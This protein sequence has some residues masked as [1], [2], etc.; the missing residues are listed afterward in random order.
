MGRL[1]HAFAVAEDDINRIIHDFAIL[2]RLA[3][4]VEKQA[5]VH[6]IL[7]GMRIAVARD[8]LKRLLRVTGAADS[9]CAEIN[10]VL[11]Q[12][13]EIQFFRDRIA[14]NGAF[15]DFEN[16][17]RFY[18]TNQIAARE[19]EQ[20]EWISFTPAILLDMAHDLELIPYLID[21]ALASPG[22]RD[23]HAALAKTPEDRQA[24]LDPPSRPWRYRPSQ[25]V[26]T[27][28]RYWRNEALRRE[29]TG[30]PPDSAGKD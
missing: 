25:L 27:G 16:A 29:A 19:T 28:P 11:G 4:P 14:H 12:L 17:G 15:P 8:T 5:I 2:G 10:R 3:L 23:R 13:G 22:E 7:G 21:M 6:A 9:V 1:V 30:R 24:I 26:K 20:V 18:T